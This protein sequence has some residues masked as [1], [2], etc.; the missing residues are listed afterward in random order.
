MRRA[1]AIMAGLAGMACAGCVSVSEASRA[2]AVTACQVGAPMVE[3]SLYLGMDRPGG[4]VSRYEFQAFLETEVVP[5]WKEGFTVLDG[6]GFWQSEASGATER[7]ASHV[8]IRIHDGSAAASAGI[9]AIRAAYIK[10]FR[11]DAVLRTDR[12]TCADF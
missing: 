1:A 9:E 3:T 11:Q 10:D 6:Q 12:A 2:P 8:L 5:R 7:E 4:T